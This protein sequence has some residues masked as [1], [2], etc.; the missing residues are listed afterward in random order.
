MWTVSPRGRPMPGRSV[1]PTLSLYFCLPVKFFKRR[2]SSTATSSA[3]SILPGGP[4]MECNSLWRPVVQ[5]GLW[6]D[7][8][9]IVA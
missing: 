9:N 3:L 4:G 1:P 8:K 6:A 5:V 2:T 7:S